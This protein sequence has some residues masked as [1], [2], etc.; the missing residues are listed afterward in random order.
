MI[1]F[2]FMFVNYVGASCWCFYEWRMGMETPVLFGI[3]LSVIIVL[4]AFP[5]SNITNSQDLVPN[6]LSG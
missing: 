1:V 3:I 6:G 4:L 5:T 2:Y